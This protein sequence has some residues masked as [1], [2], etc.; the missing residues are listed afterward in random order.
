MRTVYVAGLP[1]RI[2]GAPAEMWHTVKLWRS[3]GLPVTVI[4]TW[5]PD[6]FWEDQIRRIG[7]AICN[8]DPGDLA[9]EIVVALCNSELMSRPD[10]FRGAQIVWGPCT[11]YLGS[12]E[13]QYYQKHPTFARYVF[14]SRFQ[15]QS[16]WSEYRAFG[17]PL[18]HCHRIRGAFDVSE[19]P[20]RPRPYREGEPFVI[21]RLSRAHP[22]K[23]A[24]DS[25]EIYEAIRDA[26]PVPLNVRVMGFK[27]F[28]IKGPVPSW[29]EILPEGA[30]ESRHFLSSLHAM[31]QLTD[32]PENWPR[33]GLEAMSCGVPIVVEHKGGWVEMLEDSE[34]GYLC[35]SRQNVVNACLDLCSDPVKRMRIAS[36]ARQTLEDRLA[37]PEMIWNCWRHLFEGLD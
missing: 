4:P 26:F 22:W 1:N 20:Y 33:T 11:S 36:K 35:E 2:G 24:Q 25:W 10:V 12:Y 32:R 9:G 13:F 37:D 19:F 21:G 17:V 6:P 29:I 31:V 7:G 30:E 18:G 15:Q 27:A 34:T 23:Y 5:K 28:S 14:Q 16:L 3:W 8:P